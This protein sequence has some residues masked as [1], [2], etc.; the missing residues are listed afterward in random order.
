MPRSVIARS[1]VQA[2]SHV[3]RFEIP[4]TAEC[5]ASLSIANSWNMLKLICIELVMPSSRII[6]C[7]PLLLLPSIFPSVR[8]YSNESVF[9]IEATASTSVLPMNIQNLFPLGLTG[10][11]S[12]Q[13]K[14][15][16]RVFSCT[17]VW[18]HRFFST[19]LSLWSNSHPSIH[20]CWESH[21]FDY[22]EPCRQ[23][24]VSAI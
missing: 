15:L 17:T 10:L 18:K 22:T 2:L 21:S 9:H 13:F 8:G 5:E 4:W 6:L 12:L 16:S 1:S 23:S 3:W 19:Q 20:D 24:D 11:I 14:R 7:H